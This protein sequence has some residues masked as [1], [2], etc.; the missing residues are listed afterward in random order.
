MEGKAR[1]PYRMCCTS[2][3]GEFCVAN[4]APIEEK[5]EVPVSM[6]F[7]MQD[8]EG[9]T[10]MKQVCQGHYGPATGIHRH[11]Q[12]ELS[13]YYLSVGDWSFKIWR[14]GTQQP[15]VVSPSLPS[16]MTV[17][18]WSPT[19]P[20][21]VFVGTDDGYLQVWDL[22]ERSHEPT[23][24]QSVGSY[25]ITSLEFKPTNESRNKFGSQQLAVGDEVGVLH[26]YDIPRI[27]IRPHAHEQRNME[28]YLD[29]ELKRVNYF[30]VRWKIRQQELEQL[31]ARLE[32]EKVE[33]QL[34]GGAE[35]MG[36]GGE[37]EEDNPFA[38]ELLFKDAMTDFQKLL[39]ED[40]EV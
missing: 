3:D 6:E 30:A 10:P 20:A 16:C 25:A 8:K 31:Q 37:P 22:L 39:A 40:E 15:I 12:A 38:D 11:P 27:L 18:R 26:I 19:R 7:G 13:D 29:R 14:I 5:K 21:I 34:A 35:G 17:G 23:I 2:E 28:R 4:W 32:K 24:S 9:K 1:D 36:A 33:A